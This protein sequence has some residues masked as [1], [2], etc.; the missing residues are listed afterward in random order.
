MGPFSRDYG[1]GGLWGY[2]VYYELKFGLMHNSLFNV[3]CWHLA[4]NCY[5][6]QRELIEHENVLLCVL[7]FST[8]TAEVSLDWHDPVILKTY[9]HIESGIE[10]ELN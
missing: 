7:L 4:S 8:M 5:L 10:A 9:N 6:S 1:K 3:T 2:T